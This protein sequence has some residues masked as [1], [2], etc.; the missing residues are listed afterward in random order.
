MEPAGNATHLCLF[1]RPMP[2]PVPVTMSVFV[3]VLVPV[4]VLVLVPVLVPVPVSA[5]GSGDA[6][7]ISNVIRT[8]KLGEVSRTRSA[9]APPPSQA[10]A[11]GDTR[12]RGFLAASFLSGTKEKGQQ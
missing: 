12:V 8:L 7:S 4:L 5:T 2:V 3:L 9:L 1:C 6:F 11:D 10:M